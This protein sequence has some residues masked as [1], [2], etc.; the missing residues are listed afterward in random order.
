MVKAKVGKGYL[1]VKGR[2]RGPRDL[3]R[4][5]GPTDLVRQRVPCGPR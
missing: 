2:H 4:Q 1:V 5:R 3:V